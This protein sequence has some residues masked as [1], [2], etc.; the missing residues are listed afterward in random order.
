MKYF[1]IFFLLI[2]QLNLSTNSFAFNVP[3]IE[4]ILEEIV[5]THNDYVGNQNVNLNDLKK[6]IYLKKYDKALILFE[7]ERGSV[8]V[9][10]NKSLINI[11]LSDFSKSKFYL[12]KAK[13]N[14][15]KKT[16]Q[17]LCEITEVVDSLI[18][19]H[20]LGEITK[21]KKSGLINMSRNPNI[22]KLIKIIVNFYKEKEN[23]ENIKILDQ[24]ENTK[25][26]FLLKQNIKTEE[27]NTFN[28][29][30]IKAVELRKSGNY[31]KA[32]QLFKK[33]ISVYPIN[34]TYANRWVMFE[35]ASIYF[36]IGDE[37]QFK[38]YLNEAETFFESKK[39]NS[40]ALYAKLLRAESLRMSDFVIQAED[41]FFEVLNATLDSNR[42]K[43]NAIS[44]LGIA[45]TYR[46]TGKISLS[47]KY[48]NLCKNI[49]YENKLTE[50]LG[51]LYRGLGILYFR[52]GKYE[53]S[54]EALLKAKEYSNENMDYLTLAK[55]QIS[56]GRLFLALGELGLSR[57]E[58][59][60]A[61]ILSQRSINPWIEVQVLTY[62]ADLERMINHNPRSRV[63]Y[64]KAIKIGNR[65]QDRAKVAMSLFG[66]G[67][68]DK[69]EKKYDDA[70]DKYREALSLY[71]S[72][73]HLQGK[74]MSLLEI[75]ETFSLTKEDLNAQEFFDEAIM[76]FEK[77]DD[78]YG[79][80][81]SW[82]K[83]ARHF[84]RLKNYEASIAFAEKSYEI[85][86]KIKND[87]E[88]GKIEVLFSDIYHKLKKFDSAIEKLEN[89]SLLFFSQK[90]Y[91]N[92]S[93]VY[94][95]MSDLYGLLK[96]PKM[97]KLYRTKFL[98]T[99]DM[100]AYGNVKK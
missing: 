17:Y 44:L 68:L 54:K 55:T 29:L 52:S 72:I 69:Y 43:L 63:L 31:Q 10:I 89:A 33:S 9:N 56:L 30:Y 14:I 50:L 32:V 45:D 23:E 77:I 87:R 35:L 71:S 28:N 98:E 60:S 41:L 13:K 37:E 39:I 62:L 27:E 21:E 57:R 78:K 82:R 83:Y 18:E 59:E 15:N 53:V 92:L 74:A 8:D 12:F 42:T 58:Y 91:L 64:D 80:T 3:A 11:L 94:K 25:N 40:A 46:I 49:A 73:D 93:I 99:Q 100:L 85:S 88:T 16:S 96:K 75:A 70:L 26:F 22:Q 38:K 48:Y 6:N 61:L 20:F 4:Q 81:K 34:N 67:V 86:M 51:P 66:I 97:E 7:E 24:I 79:L 84:F 19:L 2:S 76:L 47:L 95:K 1:N 90:D 5:I 36:H 65:I